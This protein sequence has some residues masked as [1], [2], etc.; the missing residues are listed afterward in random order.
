MNCPMVEYS[1]APLGDDL[2]NGNTETMLRFVVARDG[3]KP[4]TCPGGTAINLMTS[5]K[6]LIWS[7]TV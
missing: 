2:V 3:V 4:P 6:L 7:G 5:G 1:E